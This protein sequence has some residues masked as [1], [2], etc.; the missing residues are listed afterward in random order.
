MVSSALFYV[1]VCWDDSGGL[2]VVPHLLGLVVAVNDGR[3]AVPRVGAS[4]FVR[5]GKFVPF[6][7]VGGV[8]DAVLR[9]FGTIAAAA[10]HA[11]VTGEAVKV[12]RPGIVRSGVRL[13][14]VSVCE[15]CGDQHRGIQKGVLHLCQEWLSNAI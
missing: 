7:L 8:F 14:D 3:N 9:G 11:G 6:A 5:V 4:E 13:G 2:Y 1:D 15:G 12:M 10:E